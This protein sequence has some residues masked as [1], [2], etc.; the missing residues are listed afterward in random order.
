[1]TD[2]RITPDELNRKLS[3]L[4]IPEQE[5]A[6]Y[7]LADEERSGLFRPALSLNPE[8]VAL[9]TDPDERRARSE[10]AMTFA[11][12]IA[13]MR[14][15]LRF[16]RM[17]ADGHSG[18][19]LVSEGDSW[20][21]YP[22]L[23]QDT[24]DHLYEQG[25]AV[26][27]LDAAGDTLENMLKEREYL[28]AIRE[29]GA[30]IFLLSAG[31]NDALG[32]G[33]L[34]AHL[35]DFDPA[36]SPAAHVLPSFD[37]LLDHALAMY[38]QVLRQ[39]EALPG[40][41]TICH[42]YDYVIP[43]AGNWLGKPMASRGITDPA[44]QRAIAA[45]MI[46]R[47]NDR[48]RRLTANFGGRAV[49]VDARHA[50]GDTLADW[51]DELHPKDPGYGRVADRFAEAI[52]RVATGAGAPRT[53]G[54]AP[55]P[56]AAR[57]GWSLHLG[58]NHIDPAHYGSDAELFGCHFDAE[59]MA[60]IAAQRGFEKRDLLLDE[61]ATR[62]AVKAAISTAAAELK[63]GDVFLLTYAGHGSQVPDFNADEDD[64]AD[65]TLC[66]FDGMLID[67]ELYELWSKF[68]DDVRIVMI[69]D[70]CHSGTVSRGSRRVAGPQEAVVKPE[71]RTRLLPPQLA[72]R[73]FRTHRDFYVAL[74]RQARGP[75]ERLLTRELDMPL[76]GPV[77]L[78]A[79]CQDNQESQDGVGNGRFTQEFLAVWDEGRY[80][81]DWQ[82]MMERIVGNMPPNQT[83]RMTLIGRSP[84]VLAAQPPFAI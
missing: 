43:N 79:G 49:H 78:L 35:R 24:I 38:E 21:Q 68:A 44:V 54:M 37:K 63:A 82:G 10:A 7:F 11:N 45:Q 41:V 32:G 84:G 31:G 57:R 83:P 74:G 8:T 27:S 39:V 80:A 56:V 19:V 71:D 1:M 15:K 20:F 30:A 81:G 26:R 58:L 6:R 60:R 66:L 50:V 9:P 42:G 76:R 16:D 29:T 47:F 48:L 12:S 4:T 3:D 34:R 67:D 51:H 62:D 72:A 14:R 2:T 17:L 55:Q 64:R 61:Q 75:D 28:E 52:R 77:L 18:P 69:S 73:T 33:N 46:D 13:R 25:F 40:V 53:R 70:S 59:D 36:L 5:L 22:I 65:E 23:L